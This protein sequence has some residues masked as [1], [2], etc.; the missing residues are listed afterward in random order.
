[1][2][3]RDRD[4]A[5][6]RA[7]HFHNGDLIPPVKGGELDGVGNNEHGHNEQHCDQRQADNRGD[8]PDRCV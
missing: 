7:H 2:C 6:G 1:M 4:K 5:V 3:I 8:I